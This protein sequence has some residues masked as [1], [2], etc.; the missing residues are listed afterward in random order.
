[1]QGSTL[2]GHQVVQVRQ[3]HEKRRLTPTGMVEALHREQFALHGIMG[4]IQQGA[5]DGHVRVCEDRLPPGFLR[6]APAPDALALDRPG[7]VGDVG[8]KAP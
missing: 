6:L 3:A 7:R 4:L 2:R 1:M 8:R 5:G